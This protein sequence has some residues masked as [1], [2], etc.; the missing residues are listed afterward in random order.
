MDV[1]KRNNIN[2]SGK[3]E[4][5]LVFGHGFG[6]DQNMWRFVTPAFQ[7][8]Y[9][10]VLFDH[11]GAGNSDLA[12]YNTVKYNTLHGY[13]TDILEIIDFLDLQDVIFVGHSVSAMMGVL[14]AIKT[15]ALF[16]KLILI[17]PSPCY[18]N[19]KNYIGGFDRADILSMLEYMERDYTLWADTFAP[20]I[21]GNPDK[22]SLGE[23]LIESFC[24]TDPDIARHFAH[25]TFLSDNRPDLPKLQ[26][27]ALIMQ[28]ADDIIA[29]EE[30]GNYVH[31]AI[32]NSTLVHLKATGHCPNLSSPLE[33]I[34]TMENYLQV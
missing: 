19:D 7:Q 1:I 28:C 12:A 25:V 29:P 16:S 34:D 6:C 18:I 21:M 8:H 5:P 4:K 22:P 10:I 27:E 11:V 20:L 24:N 26:T 14:S 32:K 3:G 2:I 13:A 33:V 31:K 17:G 9:K 30:V 23:E 15:P